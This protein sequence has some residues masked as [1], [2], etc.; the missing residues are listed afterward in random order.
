MTYQA[1][2]PSLIPKG[3][4]QPTRIT[5][6]SDISRIGRFQDMYDNPSRP[7][8]MDVEVPEEI[9]K[10]QAKAAAIVLDEET[11]REQ[12][13]AIFGSLLSSDEEDN[14]SNAS[15]ADAQ[16]S[17]DD[18]DDRASVVSKSELDNENFDLAESGDMMFDDEN[19]DVDTNM[20]NMDTDEKNEN[21]NERAEICKTIETNTT[22]KVTVHKK[23]DTLV[24]GLQNKTPLENDLD[25]LDYEEDLDDEYE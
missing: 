20:E 25:M 10:E 6:K 12:E 3:A 18:E 22:Q 19:M 13:K 23:I 15:S 5:N 11:R 9:R 24:D 2:K 16:F 21:Q 1:P 8:L 17:D 14:M 4:F 7:K